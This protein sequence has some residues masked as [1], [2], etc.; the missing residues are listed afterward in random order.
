MPCP[1]EKPTCTDCECS[2]DSA[3]GGA[4]LV[5]FTTNGNT[6]EGDVS[7]THDMVVGTGRP[8]SAAAF[9]DVQLKLESGDKMAQLPRIIRNFSLVEKV[10]VVTG[11]ARGLGFNMTE[12]FLQA[13]A[14][15][16]AILDIL[17]AEG[18]AAAE[19]LTKSYDVPVFFYKV[20]ITKDEAVEKVFTQIVKD[21]GSVDVLLCSAGIADSNM[22][23]ET[24]PM[25]RFRRL[26]DI[27]VSG[28][29][30][31]SQEAAKQMMKQFSGGSIILMAS[32]SSHIVNYPQE[33][34]C[35]NASKAAVRHL[36]ASLA[37]EWSKYGI[38]VNSVSPGYMDT[39][40]NRAP[41]L[42]AQKKIW[43]DRT[44]MN[45][46]GNEDELNNLALFLA[47]PASSFMT[48]SDVI[49]DG[50]YCLP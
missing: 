47:S 33:Q 15:G 24:Y 28:L 44:P 14:R 8:G 23:A 48:G 32:M 39:E 26:M 41:A 1:R 9:V 7:R 30:K 12:G 45:R 31:C 36:G 43:C 49:I 29:M 3:D 5:D 19:T 35:Y 4:L 37:L 18:E 16:A 50:G 46:L 21:L 22:P 34:C 40:L 27:N 38:R 25:A 2:T 11:G 6:C 17:E 13:G 20:D 42:A 10:C